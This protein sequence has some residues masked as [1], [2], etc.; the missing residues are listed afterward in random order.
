MAD[1]SCE[2]EW[3]GSRFHL[4]LLFLFMYMVIIGTPLNLKN[5]WSTGLRPFG[6]IA[7]LSEAYE[8]T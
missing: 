4:Y 5:S 1:I 3:E 8:W 2:G 6:R 7:G